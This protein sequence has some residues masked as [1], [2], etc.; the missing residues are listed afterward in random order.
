[1]VDLGNSEYGDIVMDPF[2]MFQLGSAAVGIGM[3]LFGD[4]DSGEEAAKKAAQKQARIS[5]KSA[6]KQNKIIKE[7][8]IPNLKEQGRL[9]ELASE[10]SRKAEMLRARQMELD[11]TR[12]RRDVIR[13]YI[14]T[15]AAAKAA[16]FA[17]GAEKG[18]GLSG[19]LAQIF[20]DYGRDLLATGQNLEIGRG[21]FAA[22]IAQSEYLSSVNML[23]TKENILNSKLGTVQNTF[24][25][26]LQAAG[27]AGQVGDTGT[28]YTQLG[29]SL[30]S[31]SETIGKLG[32]NLFG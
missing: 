20:G 18:S 9:S 22:N 5:K 29:T 10:E 11:A 8:I 12:Q 31:S 21:I 15:S 28:S 24:N 14:R 30:V 13:N 32:Q 7:K 6:K 16:A 1:M 2:T 19:G 23:R 25:A 4:D 26:K 27:A 17:Q 3:Q